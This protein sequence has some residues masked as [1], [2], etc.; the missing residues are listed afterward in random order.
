[1]GNPGSE[2]NTLSNIGTVYADLGEK[3]KALDYYYQ[4][5]ALFRAVHDP[6]G[7]GLALADLMDYWKSRQNPSLAVLF[8]K[9]AIDRFQQ[10]RRNIAGLEKESQQS[11]LKSKEDYYRELAEML[12]SEGRLPE[13]QQVLDLLK[14]EEYS[15]FTQRRGD[16]S[17]ETGSVA[18]TPEEENA[19]KEYEQITANIT[20]IGEEWTQ[21]HAKSSRSAEEEKRYTELSDKLTA[22]NQRL[23]A[24]LNTLYDSFGKGDP[25]NARW[26]PSMMRPAPSN[27]WWEHSG[28]ERRLSTLWCWTISAS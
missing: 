7:E 22:A 5:L 26:K 4:S 21:L 24:Y 23:Q 18:R 3:Q 25:A 17:S 12:V 1:M 8:G 11:F 15:E 10:V 28:P 19:N 2:A 16:A 20:T 9:Q 14:A 6:L 13:A 27:R